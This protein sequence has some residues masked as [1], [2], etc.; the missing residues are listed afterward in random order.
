MSA[1]AGRTYARLVRCK[2]AAAADQP[3]D[4]EK[5]AQADDGATEIVVFRPP[6]R[7]GAMG[8]I[9][10][11]H[12]PSVALE[13]RGQIAVHVIEIGQGEIGLA[14]ERLETAARVPRAIPQQPAADRVR[15]AG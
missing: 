3:R 2:G 14:P 6:G 13:E 12:V 8:D 4:T 5:I 15:R 9:H 10:M 11:R 7:P 1:D